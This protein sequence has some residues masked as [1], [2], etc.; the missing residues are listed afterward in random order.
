MLKRTLFLLITVS[1]FSVLLGSYAPN[2]A[3]PSDSDVS[4]LQANDGTYRR[5]RVPILM[6]HYVSELPEDADDIRKGLTVSPD[7]FQAHVDYLKNQGYETIQFADLYQ[8]LD[9]GLSLPS[10]PII[11]T[12]DDGH[13]DHYETVFPILQTA[14]YK[15]I[16]FIISGYVDLPQYLTW[17]QIAEMADAGMDMQPHTKTHPDLRNRN[18]DFLVYE[19]T[20]SRDSVAFHTNH[21]DTL[22]YPVGRYDDFVLEFMPQSGLRGAVTTQAGVWHTTNNGYRIS[23]LRVSGDMGVAGLEHL[24]NYLP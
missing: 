3:Q 24:L 13:I 18:Y 7:Q 19:I 2:H 23:R 8:A 1:V 21:V 12:F 6:Y 5:V 9:H 16:F 15:G 10:K 4:T 20:G 11:L 22:S 14:D 17:E